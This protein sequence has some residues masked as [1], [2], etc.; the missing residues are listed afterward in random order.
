[1][2]TNSVDFRPVRQLITQTGHP[3]TQ[4]MRNIVDEHRVLNHQFF[5][6]LREGAVEPDTLI[7]WALQ[8]RHVAYMFPQ[9]IA[10]IVAGIPANTNRAVRA[11]MPLIE[12][13]W[14]EAGEGRLERAHSTLMDAL[15]TS[16]G[17]ASNALNVSAFASTRRFIDCQFDITR[18]NAIAGA[19]AFCYANEYLALREYPP[20]QEA[21]IAVFPHANTRFFEANWE[22]DGHHTELAEECLLE[23]C[24]SQSDFDAARRGAAIALDTRLAF[25]DELYE[26]CSL[27]S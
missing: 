26:I 21:V 3:F 5:K 24:D 12:N 20:I 22:V 15:L 8:D 14:E 6:H 23:L 25:Y 18:E 13:L 10:L 27:D 17:V 9:L 11:R 1:M 4:S 7:T 2:S 16:M 19:G